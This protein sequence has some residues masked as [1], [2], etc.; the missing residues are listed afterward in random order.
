MTS[1]QMGDL[2]KFA[3]M[4]ATHRMWAISAIHGE[5]GKLRHIH[6]ALEGRLKRGDRVVYLGNFMGRGAH[7]SETLDELVSFRRFFLARFQNFTRDIVY[8]RGAQEEMW[9]KL[10]QLQFATDPRGVLSWMIDQGVGASLSAYGFD[11]DEGFHEAAAG[12]MQLTRWTNKVRRAM[13]ER[14]GHYQIMGELKRAAYPDNGTTLYVNSGINPTRPLETQKDSFWWA[15]NGFLK[16][17]ENF[18]PFTRV[19][20]GYDPAQAGVTY[21]KHAVSLDGG[22]GFGGNLVAACIHLDGEVVEILES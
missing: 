3:V 1:Q 7:I 21:N 8:L 14:P 4:T 18:G 17:N 22:C 2:Q 19:F 10:L 5:V 11:P 13:Q 15:S 12:A 9:Q 6:S 16:L 20:R